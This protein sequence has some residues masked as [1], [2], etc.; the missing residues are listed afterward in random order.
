MVRQLGMSLVTMQMMDSVRF[1]DDLDITLA[2]DNRQTA[3][4]QMTNLEIMMQPVI[5]RASLV[6]INLITSIIMHAV[7]LYSDQNKSIMPPAADKPTRPSG[8]STQS[9]SQ[10]RHSPWHV[11]QHMRARS[12]LDKPLVHLSKE[13]VYLCS[14]CTM[15]SRSIESMFVVESHF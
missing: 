2:L 15:D 8:P 4:H 13:K 11:P 10:T 12:S 9:P 6:D 3:D 5:L 1:L 14:S 7:N